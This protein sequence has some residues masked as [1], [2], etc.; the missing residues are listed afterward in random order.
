M[1]D[2]IH[3]A[4]R[5]EQTPRKDRTDHPGQ[6]TQPPL[7]FAACGYAGYNPEMFTDIYGRVKKSLGG[8]A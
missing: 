3:F 6:A 4:A 7:Y 8:G 2:P 1:T 5:I